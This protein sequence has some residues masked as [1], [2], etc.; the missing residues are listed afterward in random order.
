MCLMTLRK[1]INKG[2]AHKG[3]NECYQVT[4]R[5]KAKQLVRIKETTLIAVTEG[6]SG[7]AVMVLVVFRNAAEP[8]L[9]RG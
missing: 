6:R 9:S 4:Y 7:S 8:T 2:A 1:Q 5:T 3:T